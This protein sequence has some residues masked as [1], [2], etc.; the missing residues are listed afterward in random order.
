MSTPPPSPNITPKYVSAD[1]I[2]EIW[3]SNNY[4]E[5]LEN[6]EFLVKRDKPGRPRPEILRDCGPGTVSIRTVLRDKKTNMKIATLHHYESQAGEKLYWDKQTKT[7][8]TAGA[9]MD[10]KR[11]YHQGVMYLVIPED[12]ASL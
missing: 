5:R 7:V 12:A 11:L 9:K 10:P 6:G 2:R 8:R 3:N 4:Q 1:E